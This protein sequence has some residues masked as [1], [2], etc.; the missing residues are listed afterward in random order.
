MTTQ[1]NYLYRILHNERGEGVAVGPGQVGNDEGRPNV[2]D[3][4]FVDDQVSLDYIEGDVGEVELVGVRD[5]ID[6][7]LSDGSD[8]ELKIIERLVVRD[9]NALSSGGTPAGTI[10]SNVGVIDIVTLEHE[11]G[12]EDRFP[13]EYLVRA[14]VAGNTL[15]I[16]PNQG[17]PFDYTP[18]FEK[19]TR[20]QLEDSVWALFSRP[21]TGASVEHNGISLAYEDVRGQSEEGRITLSLDLETLT[22]GVP[23]GTDY[24]AF[25]DDGETNKPTKK[26]RINSLPI[27]GGWTTWADVPA[28]PNRGGAG[29]DII[30]VTSL[31]PVFPNISGDWG[32]INLSEIGGSSY[33]AGDGI[34]ISGNTISAD[35]GTVA[36]TVAEG[37]H[38]HTGL[39]FNPPVVTTPVDENDK[40]VIEVDDSYARVDADV[41][42][43]QILRNIDGETDEFLKRT[44]S[45]IEWAVPTGGGV[46]GVSSV[47]AG[48]GLSVNRTTGAIT[49]SIDLDN[50][51]YATPVTTDSIAFIDESATGDPTRLTRIDTLLALA[52]SSGPAEYIRRL[53]V[54]GNTLSWDSEGGTDGSFSPTGDSGGGLSS[55]SVGTGLDVSTASGVATI[56]L[57]LSEITTGTPTLDDYVI[58]L[59]DSLTGDPERKA[60]IRNILALGGG[61]GSGWDSWDDV[62]RPTIY[63]K[64]EYS[65]FI[66]YML[67]YDR[68]KTEWRS[69]SPHDFLLPIAERQYTLSQFNNTERLF[70]YDPGGNSYGTATP[71]TVVSAVVHEVTQA[72]YDAT[73]T[74]RGFYIITD[75]E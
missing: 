26:A 42:I 31:S 61:T 34:D 68:E 56:S 60:R 4:V 59:D 37:N 72:V 25:S 27:S 45:G 30:P 40:L 39:P 35:F 10:P 70:A 7:R 58:F 52:A 47:T 50:L 57:D 13:E 71:H 8:D 16:T 18:T 74:K 36:D 43:T 20:E 1:N 62:P 67:I 66:D 54:S 11:G 29:Y 33:T 65:M 19:I 3:V 32:F 63:T 48:S 28:P 24:I 21:S 38:G 44:A 75:A 46:A 22:T 64:S 51:T 73:T 41:A 49:I 53:S 23:V 12:E 9:T 14:S 17:T 15:S 5:T 69:I 2:G 55:I 6:L